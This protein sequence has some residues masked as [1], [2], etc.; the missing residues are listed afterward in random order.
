MILFKELELNDKFRIDCYEVDYYFKTSQ[1]TAIDS[2]GDEIEILP[3]AEVLASR[4]S[5][6]IKR[7]I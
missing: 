5:A 4:Q 6:K 7:S 3:E 2:K 1:Y